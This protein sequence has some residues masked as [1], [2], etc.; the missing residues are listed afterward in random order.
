MKIIFLDVYKTARARISKDTAGGYGTQNDLGDGLFGRAITTYIKSSVFWPN[1]AFA[2][3]A[4][5]LQR[6]GHECTYVKCGP[7]EVARLPF[8]NVYFVCA[9][10]VCFETEIE[11][12]KKILATTNKATKIYYCGQIA[13]VLET[14]VPAEVTIL[15]G[16]YEFLLQSLAAGGINLED[17]ASKRAV[18]IQNG[19]PSLL[20]HIDWRD[21]TFGVLK[22]RIL[23]RDSGFYP[24]IAT[25]GCPYS[26][27]EYC[28][29][30]LAQG[31]NTLHEDIE[32]VVSKLR[33]L[34]RNG[35]R[36]H[37]V[38]RDPVFSINLAYAKKLLQAI[39]DAR[40]Q[41]DFSVELHLKNID[42]EFLDLSKRASVKW[43]KFGV[44]SADV[45]VRSD[46]KRHSLTNDEIH[47]RI[48]GLRKV[49]IKSLAMFIL[50][51]PT[52]TVNSC[53]ASVK[54]AV[55]VDPDITQFSIFTPYPGTPYYER[56]KSN[57]PDQRYENFTQF[58]LVYPHPVFDNCSA[59][60]IMESAYMR[61]ILAARLGWKNS[62]FA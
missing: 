62:F 45:N 46:V 10:I 56:T 14:L 47:A 51:Q 38:F 15:N 52:D 1:L 20:S 35:V 34:Q 30:P 26:C 50:C 13:K 49:G 40:L 43:I 48:Q 6:Q 61:T 53:M 55:H 41:L 5:E 57:I 2:Q 18:F 36:E 27:Y 4:I 39:I 58:N 42:A 25:R 28:T 33:K 11:A 23:A 60:R 59:R 22:N 32:S 24:F 7:G 21:G 17:I 29:Y 8:A 12:I 54:Y 9:S 19:D 44:E 31:R 37:V 3:L 16:N